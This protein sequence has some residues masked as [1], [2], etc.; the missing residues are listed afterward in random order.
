MRSLPPL[1]DLPV[2]GVAGVVRPRNEL[3]FSDG[4][5]RIRGFLGKD[6]AS[7][8]LIEIHEQSPRDLTDLS[9]IRMPRGLPDTTVY[10]WTA[11]MRRQ[12]TYQY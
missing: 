6:L 11:L 2:Q 7:V 1:H 8:L 5:V 4:I 12:T 3:R 10:D 9:R